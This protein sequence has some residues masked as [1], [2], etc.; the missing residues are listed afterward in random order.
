MSKTIKNLTTAR[1]GYI[2]EQIVADYLLKKN[3]RVYA[4]V[5]DD[6]RIDLAVEKDNKYTTIQVKYHTTRMSGSSI[7]VMVKSTSAD[8]IAAPI[9]IEDKTHIIWYKNARKNKTYTIA[10]SV[11]RPKN[12]QVKKVNFYESF[13]RSPFD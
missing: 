11:A 12:N 6:F 9:N 1:R 2:G 13:L 3:A 7:Q 10:F 4:P 8:W 5:V